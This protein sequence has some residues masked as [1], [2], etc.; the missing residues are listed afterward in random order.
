MTELTGTWCQT[1]RS[2]KIWTPENWSHQIWA[3]WMKLFIFDERDFNQ[4]NQTEAS[5][6][7]EP[8]WP[9]IMEEAGNQAGLLHLGTR[10]GHVYSVKS[11]MSPRL[12][13]DETQHNFFFPNSMPGKHLRRCTSHDLCSEQK[14]MRPDKVLSGQICSLCFKSSWWQPELKLMCIFYESMISLTKLN[15]GKP[16]KLVWWSDLN[17]KR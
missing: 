11:Q 6:A 5:L 2:F 3:L 7:M 10:S 9:E 15:L 17:W 12:W 14:Q 1:C 16:V 8:I 4:E 13:T